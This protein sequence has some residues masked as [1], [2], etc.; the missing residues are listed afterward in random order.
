M[1]DTVIKYSDVRDTLLT[2]DLV[3]MQGLDIESDIIQVVEH[4]PWS[5]VAMV[6]RINGVDSPFI[7]ESTPLH[8]LEDIVLHS[9]KSGARIVSLDDRLRIGIVK[10]LYKAYA[11][12]RLAARRTSDMMDKLKSYIENVH[13]LPYPTDWELA[14]SY[15]KGRFLDEKVNLPSLFCAELIAETYMH[16]GL[17]DFDHPPNWYS[18]KDFSSEVTLPLLK[19]ARLQKELVFSADE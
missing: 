9:K 14:K 17:L 10:K 15:L 5:H 11:L 2:G 1:A 4:S 16:M 6:I 19:R 12:R 13:S 18:P 8:F 3:L 7:W